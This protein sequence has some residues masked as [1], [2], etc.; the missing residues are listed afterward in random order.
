MQDVCYCYWLALDCV[1][2]SS[3][4]FIFEFALSASLCALRK[5]KVFLFETFMT[6]LEDFQNLEATGSFSFHV[7]H[8]ETL[9]CI[10][11]KC[12][13]LKLICSAGIHSALCTLGT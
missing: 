2:I 11:I 9:I 10:S 13:L 8:E 5:I 4:H 1:K 3:Y 7:I 12:Q 6:A